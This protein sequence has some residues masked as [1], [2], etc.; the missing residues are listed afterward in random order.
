[1]GDTPDRARN[2]G[3][4]AP[5]KLRTRSKVGHIH[6][7]GRAMGLLLEKVEGREAGID[8]LER[9]RSVL[10]HLHR[11]GLTHDDVNRYNFVVGKEK[12]TLIDFGRAKADADELSMRAEME[13]L[14][15]QLTEETGRGGGFRF[16][17][18]SND[19][20]GELNS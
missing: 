19:D 7:H 18:N 20:Q 16:V 11:L 12:V 17:E 1:M 5:G 10:E 2:P 6:E 4:S 13:S 15:N 14:R 9:C 8:D 3:V